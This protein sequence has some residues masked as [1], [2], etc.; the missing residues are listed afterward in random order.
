[1]KSDRIVSMTFDFE[2]SGLK[3]SFQA[4]FWEKKKEILKNLSFGVRSHRT[5]GFIGLNGAGKTTTIK[6]SLGFIKP[7][8]GHVYFFGSQGLSSESKKKLG[9]L[10]ERPYYYEFLTATEFLR[11]HWELS[12]GGPG[13]ADVIKSTLDRV[14]LSQAAN[15]R[16]RSFS[17]GMLQRAGMAQAILRN[18]QLLI[19]DEPMSGLDPDGR[20]LIKE[21]IRDQKQAGTTIFFSSHLLN[22][23]DELCDDL[24]VIDQGTLIFSGE[25][26][27]FVEEGHKNV[28][29]SFKALRDRLNAPRGLT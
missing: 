24:V 22:D 2:V 1:M 12:G 28:E 3:K 8:G 13:S 26:K 20:I 11:F 29:Q 15:K 18:P 25:L 19:L 4:N 27:S 7:D 6:S 23:M 5:T 21:I 14:G 9:Y 17:K 10:P 16:L